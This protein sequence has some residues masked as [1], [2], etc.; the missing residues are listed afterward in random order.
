MN[1]VYTKDNYFTFYDKEQKLW[2]ICR[3]ITPIKFKVILKRSTEEQAKLC[4]DSAG[5]I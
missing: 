3:Q 2:L 1:D 5:A 4:V